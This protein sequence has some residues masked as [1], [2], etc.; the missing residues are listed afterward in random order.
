V[1]ST[2]AEETFDLPP[3]LPDGKVV[4]GRHGRLFLAN[5]ANRLLDQHRGEIRFSEDQLRQWRLLLETRTAWLEQRGIR[6][7]FLIAP[8][9]HS[10]YPEDLPD[11]V[12]T[13]SERPVEQLLGHLAAHG[14]DS[15]VVY[16]LET[17]KA[18]R[19]VHAYPK[20]GS[21]WSGLGAFLASRALLQEIAR[22]LPID[23]PAI[24][25]FEVEELTYF[26]DLGAKL[27][28]QATS[29]YV[30][31]T[32]RDPRVHLIEDNRVRNTGRRMI[33]EAREGSGTLECLVYGDS[34]AVR[35]LPFLAESFRRVT[36]VHMPNLDF[37]LVRDLA[38]D[39]VVKIMNERFLIAV[40]VDLPAKTHAELAAE[41]IAAHDVMPP[42]GPRRPG[43]PVTFDVALVR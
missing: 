27:R 5:D 2:P 16:P 4:E 34:F 10:V 6:H 15:G 29:T 21:H 14:L 25:E 37:D 1:S 30:R 32:P 17:L 39:V 38:P 43:R 22:E 11:G 18:G 9:A 23:V 26:G 13:A 24:D 31:L 8:N 19:D 3:S 42:R 28:P 7:F 36:F 40:P 12:E 20:T 41:K 35:V 33:Y